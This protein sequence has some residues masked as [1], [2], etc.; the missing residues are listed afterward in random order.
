MSG[1]DPYCSLMVKDGNVKAG[2]IY[3]KDGAKWCSA[4]DPGASPTDAEFSASQ[5][6]AFASGLNNPSQFATY[7]MIIGSVTSVL[8]TQSNKAII[9]VVTTDGASASNVASHLFIAQDLI[10]KGFELDEEAQQLGPEEG[11][12]EGLALDGRGLPAEEGAPG[13]LAI[14]VEAEAEP[15]LAL[16]L[17]EDEAEPALL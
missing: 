7:G 1:W 17:A 2:S 11:G 15:E 9:T 8:G 6:K 5:A 4:A 10:K 12:L 14:A 13:A 3:G 16:S